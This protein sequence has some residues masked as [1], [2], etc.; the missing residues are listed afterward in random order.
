VLLAPAV[1]GKAGDGL[2]FCV[3]TGARPA[4]TPCLCYGSSAR[5]RATSVAISTS[6]SQH[7]LESALPYFM[8]K[9]PGCCI[10]QMRAFVVTC[11]VPP[12]RRARTKVVV[13]QR[14]LQKS[15]STCSH[16]VEMLKLA[17]REIVFAACQLQWLRGT[18][19]ESEQQ[20]DVGGCAC[21][22]HSA[23]LNSN[24]EPAGVTGCVRT[25][26]RVLL[27]FMDGHP[28]KR[29]QQCLT[30]SIDLSLLASPMDG[31]SIMNEQGARLSSHMKNRSTWHGDGERNGLL[32]V[33]L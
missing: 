4:M 24:N 12:H 10:Q 25:Y 18:P 9:F 7:P 26:L 2:C 31:G 21:A 15:A 1:T 11:R 22:R 3:S 23:R 28:K 32:V 14:H 19:S 27:C 17:T 20:R 30:C 8:G 16:H 29:T 13:P 5:T 6:G 33:G